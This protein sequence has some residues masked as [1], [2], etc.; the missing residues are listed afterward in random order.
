MNRQQRRAA[1]KA[2]GRGIPQFRSSEWADNKLRAAVSYHRTRQ[3]A[4][5]MRLYAEILSREPKHVVAL[6]NLG[7][8]KC[9][10]G[11]ARQATELIG[12]AI[13]LQPN[14][15]EAHNSLGVALKDQGRLEEAVAACQKAVR[16]KP[17]YAEAHNNLGIA[18]QEQGRLEEAVAAFDRALKLKPDIAEVHNNLGVALKG[19]GRLEEA[20]AAYQKAVRL[21]PNYAE[22]HNHLGVASQEQG[23]LEEALAAFDRALKLK[24]DFAGAHHNL[25]LALQEQGKLEDAL[26]RFRSALADLM[27][28]STFKSVRPRDFMSVNIAHTAL[29]ALKSG[30]EAEHVP[31]FLAYGTLLGIVRDGDLL[32][33]DKDMDVGLPWDISR[34]ALVR[35]LTVKHGFSRIGRHTPEK[36]TWNVGL[37]HRETGIFI[38]LFF[39][40][41]DG[42][43]LLSG[44]HHL[45]VPLLWRFGHFTTRP[46]EFLGHT[47]QVP[48]PPERFFQEI[49]GP[50]WQ[51][52][53][54]YFDTMVSGRNRIPGALDVAICFAF[55]RLFDRINCGEWDKAAGYCR[56]ILAQYSDPFIE[57]VN[58]WLRQRIQT[59]NA[60]A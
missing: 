28:Q 57:E 22:A 33:H 43:A 37:S 15:A 27:Q 10:V 58:Q 54:P 7:V 6:S 56:Q 21:E 60:Q 13:A 12:K 25:G 51:T 38:D 40:K 42:D 20:V 11:E 59:E 4:E 46:L 17:N 34:E 18:I 44:I 45:P 36:D 53:D 55:S 47:W 19:Q 32:P 52:P 14:Y 1:S 16:L 26:N 2:Q 41:P 8:L 50:D 3:L 23:R 5:A 9:Q 31:F 24:P 49:Y 35:A 30:L 29:L 48:D 39:F